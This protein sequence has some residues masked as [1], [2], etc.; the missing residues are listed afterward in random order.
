RRGSLSIGFPSIA[1]EAQDPSIP[2][3]SQ[4]AKGPI[5]RDQYQ[6]IGLLVF[7]GIGLREFD[8]LH[9]HKICNRGLLDAGSILIDCHHLTND[10]VGVR[11]RRLFSVMTCG[12]CHSSDQY[13]TGGQAKQVTAE[14]SPA[15]AA[16]TLFPGERR[17]ERL[18]MWKQNGREPQYALVVDR[19]TASLQ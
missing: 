4:F 13:S 18:A 16:I 10:L 9:L 2:I 17:E 5:L 11:R 19:H 3:S 12:L 15:R 6:L 7:Q 1:I 14:P 8:S